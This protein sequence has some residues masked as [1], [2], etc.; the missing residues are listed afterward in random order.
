MSLPGA[1]SGLVPQALKPAPGESA[2][3]GSKGPEEDPSKKG[4]RLL[5]SWAAIAI[6]S[7]V[8]A[9]FV[10]T[11]T[12][13]K[14]VLFGLI[15]AYFLLPLEKF[16]ERKLPKASSKDALA[17]RASVLTFA[18]LALGL[19]IALSA[20][21]AIALPALSKAGDRIKD[22]AS[23]SE[24]LKRVE[25]QVKK[26]LGFVSD[27]NAPSESPSGERSPK[28]KTSA[29]K[30]EALA[31]WATGQLENF[32]EGK[33]AK[34]EIASIAID[35]GQGIVSSAAAVTKTLSTFVFD[36]LLSLFFLFY[37][38]QKMAVFERREEEGGESSTG[39]WLVKGIFES[40][41]MPETGA[42]ARREAADVIDKICSMLKIWVRGYL[43]IILVESCLYIAAFLLFR[44]PYA[45]PLG[46][47]AGC[48]I[49]LPLIGPLASLGLTICVCLGTGSGSLFTIVGV[50]A[51]YA[52]IHGAVEQV[53]L[54]P[55]LVG[56]AL[57]LTSLETI[58]VVLLGGLF[59]GVPGMIFAVPAAS[60][61]K[62]LIPTIYRCW[63]PEDA[64]K[65]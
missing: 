50:L 43:S 35:N 40:P 2:P 54:Y 23:S 12:F 37:F 6:V 26:D 4:G 51:A 29:S 57:G 31:V 38:L 14:S 47:L 7:V 55:R 30:V 61:L 10:L 49:L 1:I 42:E 19:G 56:K 18:S 3:K 20:V 48:T 27:E 59:A 58:I 22:W 9:V 53:F 65:A 44:V 5:K 34:Q 36:L 45:L 8:I 15:L 46:I 33:D 25:S 28:A 41:W 24:T 62:Y 17:F 16:F 39:A 11:A 63:T 52:V 32:L 21:V 60:V 64:K 13:L